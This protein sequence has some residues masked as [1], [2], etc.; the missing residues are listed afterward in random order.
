MAPGQV[1]LEMGLMASTPA[2]VLSF[3][4]RSPSLGRAPCNACNVAFRAQFAR[5]GRI[6]LGENGQSNPGQGFTKS[7]SFLLDSLQKPDQSGG[8]KTKACGP[9][10]NI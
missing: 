8:D 9:S 7:H 6:V 3:T 5:K 1:L 10:L 2:Q 4:P